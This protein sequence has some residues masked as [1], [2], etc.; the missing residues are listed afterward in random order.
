MALGVWERV[1]LEAGPQVCL[2]RSDYGLTKFGYILLGTNCCRH[3]SDT[4][5][6]LCLNPEKQEA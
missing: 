5:Y 6:A 3:V 4:L 2:G 1:T